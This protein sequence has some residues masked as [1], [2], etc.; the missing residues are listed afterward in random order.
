MRPGGPCGPVRS[1][2][3]AMTGTHSVL[4]GLVCRIVG[5]LAFVRSQ[6]LLEV[7]RLPGSI[8]A[9]SQRCHCQL[10]TR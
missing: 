1:A 4:M 5:I 2:G 7:L 3:A 9:Y 6:L 10:M 8:S